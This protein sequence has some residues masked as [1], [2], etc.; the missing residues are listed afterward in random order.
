[1][2]NLIIA[3]SVLSLMVLIIS[4]FSTL[5][6]G[7]DPKH[8]DGNLIVPSYTKTDFQSSLHSLNKRYTLY[9]HHERKANGYGIPVLFLP[10]N[11]GNFKQVRTLGAVATRIK[12][13]NWKKSKPLQLYTSNF[14]S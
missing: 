5:R 12:S 11:A 8:C 3:W 6:Y 9:R 7:K 4:I 2:K 10:G 1:M 14:E 13:W